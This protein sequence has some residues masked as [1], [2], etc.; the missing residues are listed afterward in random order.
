[1][2]DPGEMQDR[3]ADLRDQLGRQGGGSGTISLGGATANVQMIG[4]GGGGGFGG[5]GGPMVIMMGGGGG[6]RGMRG[7]NI[8]KPHGSIFFNYGGSGLDAKS[9]S[10]NG[11]PEN[12]ASYNQNRFGVTIGG[13]LN[14]PHIYK[15]G[16][17]TF[18]F[19]N[20]SGSRS[21]NPYDVFSTVPTMAERSG[22]FS[23]L[24]VQL[25]DPVTHT[26]LVNNQIANINPAAAQLLSFIPT[27]NLPGNSRNFHFV[28][29]SPSDSDTG[30]V[31]FNHNFG[32]QQSGMLGALGLAGPGGNRG[33]GNIDI[34]KLKLDGT[35]K[36]FTRLTHFN[37]YEAG[38]A[39]NPV[40]ST[41]GRFVAFQ[42]ARTT[43][44]AGVGYG[45]L[46]YWFKK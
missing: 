33:G 12:K 16:T 5:G 34:W 30:L 38:K 43:D 10:L 8:N 27:P 15:G 46:I 29:A 6:G 37:D 35:G 32:P 25:L 41:D 31:R 11:Q 39:S 1:M 4:G 7:F 21:T 9:Y 24:P 18:L 44:P 19:G 13:P 17:K 14:I 40:V 36:D 26:P 2:F 22:D 42:A 23:A 45:I 3:I 28:S 20:Y